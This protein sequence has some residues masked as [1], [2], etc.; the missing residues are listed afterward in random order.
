MKAFNYS[1]ADDIIYYCIL[2]IYIFNVYVFYG[3]NYKHVERNTM[4]SIM[5]YQFSNN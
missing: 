1:W 3:E 5:R 4:L 2:Y